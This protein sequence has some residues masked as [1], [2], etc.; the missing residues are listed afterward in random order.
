MK[1]VSEPEHL[2]TGLGGYKM[3]LFL[4]LEVQEG[5]VTEDDERRKEREGQPARYLQG[6]DTLLE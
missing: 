5:L 2:L 1:P 3:L 4:K 6:E